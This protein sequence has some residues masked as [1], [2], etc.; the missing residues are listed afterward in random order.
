VDGD[1]E[2]LQEL[3]ARRA[4]LEAAMA[5]LEDEKAK[6]AGKK[7]KPAR[8]KVTKSVKKLQDE[9]EV[10]LDASTLP[11]RGAPVERAWDPSMDILQP[12]PIH[13]DRYRSALF[14][15]FAPL[16]RCFDRCSGGG[17]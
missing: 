9:L 1:S 2:K 15:R 8:Q 5:E 7:N 11:G 13:L 17:L 10:G 4:K 12:L 3:R 6:L 14:C 16:P